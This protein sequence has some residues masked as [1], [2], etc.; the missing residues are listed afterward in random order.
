VKKNILITGV[1]GRSIGSGILH[2]ISRTVDDVKNRWLTIGTDANPFSWGLYI[3]DYGE[4]VPEA[5]HPEYIS[6][7]NKII[8]AYSVD[9]IIPGTQIEG[10]F[11]LGNT[12]KLNTVQIIANKKELYPLMMDKSHIENTLK[13]FGADY[14]E[15]A[16]IAN[17]QT[18]IDKYGFPIIVKP[19]RDSGGS[20]GLFII[21]SLEELEAIQNFLDKSSEPCVQPYIGDEKE[22]YTVGVLTDK[23]GNLIDSIVVKRELLGLSLYMSRKI[24]NQRYS[25]SSGYSQGYIVKNQKIQEFCEKFALF[26]GSIGPLNLQL[27][28]V[29]D[30]IFVFEI[31]PRFSGTTPIRADA[32]FNEVDILLRNFLFGEKFGRLSYRFDVAAIRAF[33]HAIVPIEKLKKINENWF[34]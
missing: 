13:E 29:K 3:A 20:R 5:N 32:G 14:I 18:I 15:T 30:K 16:P 11:L 6:Y 8:E 24:N 34:N 2:S 21:N 10:Q 28:V 25:I 27:R 1:G 4:I 7:I 22:E 33:E 9:A 19:S 12:D 26:L 23:N 17:F 31:H